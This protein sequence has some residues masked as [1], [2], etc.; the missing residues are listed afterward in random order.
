MFRT[1]I[2]PIVFI[3]WGSLVVLRVA[4]GDINSGAYGAGQ[5][6][7]AVV[8]AIVVVSAVRSLRRA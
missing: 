3:I 6:A 1:R 5:V 8:G 2:L 7:A 4:A